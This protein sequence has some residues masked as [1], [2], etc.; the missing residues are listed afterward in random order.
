MPTDTIK[1]QSRALVR[2]IYNTMLERAFYAGG[3][4]ALDSLQQAGGEM[5]DFAALIEQVKKE[6]DWGLRMLIGIGGFD[7]L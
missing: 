7:E 2:D 3:R 4:A 6:N 1:D 5:P